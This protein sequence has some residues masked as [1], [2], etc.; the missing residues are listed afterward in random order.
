[1]EGE[2]EQGQGLARSK[3]SEQFHK[4]IEGHGAWVGNVEGQR[5]R[6]NGRRRGWVV[7]GGEESKVHLSY[8]ILVTESFV[9]L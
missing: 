3:V 2:E 9:F 8:F 6:L 4:I 1:M 5:W 7:R